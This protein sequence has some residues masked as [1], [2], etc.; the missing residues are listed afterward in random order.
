MKQLITMLL[1]LAMVLSLAACGTSAPAA[2]EAPAAAAPAATE[3]APAETEAAPAGPL[4]SEPIVVMT[5]AGETA[6]IGKMMVMLLEENGF[7]VDDQAGNLQGGLDLAVELIVNR[8]IHM[9][10][11]YTGN[12]MYRYGEEGDPVWN[13]LE[14]GWERIKEY[15][16]RD[17]NLVWLAPCPANNTELLVVTNEFAEEHGIKDMYDFAEYVNNGGELKLATPQYWVEYE[18]GLPGLERAYG[19]EVREDQLVIGARAEKEVAAGID[20]LNCTMTFT[21]DGILD[22]LGLYLIE[23]PLEVPPYYAPTPVVVGELLEQYPQIQE[24]F[25]SVFSGIDQK[26]LTSMNADMLSK[27]MTAEEVARNY[28]VEHGFIK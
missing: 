3:A 9:N 12:G 21:T 28:L 15:D 25:D 6:I 24:I 20:G 7:L 18:Q 23:D 11:M 5:H 13:K 10:V 19:F 26:T 17:N 16:K 4:N 8:D 1:A 14:S 27:G 2:T 22:E